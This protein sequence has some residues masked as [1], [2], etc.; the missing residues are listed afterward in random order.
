MTSWRMLHVTLAPF[1]A[2]LLDTSTTMYAGSV[3]AGGAVRL[4]GSIVQRVLE[5][6]VAGLSSKPLKLLACTDWAVMGFSFHHWPPQNVTAV[7]VAD[8]LSPIT[9]L[10]P[11]AVPPISA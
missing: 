1:G 11:A 2:I 8:F 7:P 5:L 9:K 3:P 10:P 6:G 4:P